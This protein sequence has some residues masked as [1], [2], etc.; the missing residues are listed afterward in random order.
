MIAAAVTV[1]QPYLLPSVAAGLRSRWLEESREM[2][3]Y[4]RGLG[5][6]P[7]SLDRKVFQLSKVVDG[8][9]A[10]SEVIRRLLGRPR[11]PDAYPGQVRR[12]WS[13]SVRASPRSMMWLVTPAHNRS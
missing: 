13:R 11:W 7:G 4:Y 3:D 9:E 10:R 2:R 5:H 8:A 6:R 1:A 12:G